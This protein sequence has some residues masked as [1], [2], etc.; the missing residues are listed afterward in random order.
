MKGVIRLGRIGGVEIGISWTVLLIIAL[1]AWALGG[2]LL[3]G[4][5]KGQS[6][7]AYAI[8]GVAGAVG[9]MLS[10]LLH[11]LGH[12]V[13]ARRDGV[14]VKRITLWLLGGLAELGGHAPTP[15]SELRIAIAGPLTS[16]AIGVT[17][18]AAAVATA[19]LNGPELVTATLSWLGLVNVVL[20]VFN[21]L[22]GAPLD[23]GRV[24]AALLWWRTG[25]ETLARWRSANAGNM[26]GQGLIFFGVALFALYGRFDGLW[27]ALIGWFVSTSAKA[28]RTS[29]EMTTAFGDLRVGDVMTHELRTADRSRTIADFVEHE[30]AMTHVGTFPLLGPHSEP[31]GVLTLSQIRAVPRDRWRTTTLDQVATPTNQMTVAHADDRLI[32]VLSNS[33]SG[34]GR[35]IVTDTKGA[36]IGL[37]TPRDVTTAFERLS[38]THHPGAGNA[39]PVG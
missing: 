9:L 6:D 26:L 18:M 11:E 3:P 29:A 2:E 5:V 30:L 28:E 1:A 33:R 24:L 38:L 4:A 23:G 20:A 15:R 7:L 21:L 31:T 19:E 13:V 8:A 34:D 32:D 10:I 17:A 35:I 37:V 36:L 16:L 39:T 25:D 12:A 14:P 22:P 27:I